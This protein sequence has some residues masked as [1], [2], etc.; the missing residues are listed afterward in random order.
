MVN[1]THASEVR[2]VGRNTQGV[3]I[4]NLKEGDRI[5]SVARVAREENVPGAT[6]TETTPEA[7]PPSEA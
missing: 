6:E 4:M 5:A 1:R 2:I 3:R 7:T